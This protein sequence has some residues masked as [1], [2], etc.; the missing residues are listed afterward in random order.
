MKVISPR[1][2]QFRR[3][4]HPFAGRI[5]GCVVGLTI[6]TVVSTTTLGQVPDAPG[7]PAAAPAKAPA[8][9]AAPTSKAPGVTPNSSFLGKDI[10]A[11]DPGTDMFTWD[12]KSWNVNNNRIFQARFEKY[13]N[14]PEATSAEDRQYQAIIAEV[15]TR[16]APGNATREN[17]DYAFKLLNRG[18]HYDIDARL[19]DALADAV[20]TVWM[21]KRQ[22][23]R[24]YTANQAMNYE[25]QLLELAGAGR[26]QATQAAK[27][28][29]KK[30]RTPGGRRGQAAATPPAATVTEESA[31]AKEAVQENADY[32]TRR[33][34]EMIARQ[35]GNDVKRELSE[36]QAKVEYQ[37]LIVQFFLQ[38]RFQHVLMATR[39]YRAIF[40]DGDSK[41]N[42]GDETK[43]LFTKTS[44]MPPTVTTLDSLANEAVRDVR[45]GV[46]AFDFLLSKEELESA[47]RRL[48]ESFTMGEFLPE[49]RTLAREKK[50]RVVTF[51][52]KSNELLAKMETKDF[53]GAERLIAELATIAKDFDA[54]RPQG[55]IDT[56]R[57]ASRL[58]L[59]AARNAAL[60]GDKETLRT[61]L[62]AAAEIWPLNPEL[63]EISQKIF[64]Q[65]D[66][67]QRAILDFD[68]LYGQKNYRRILEES[69]RFIAATAQDA[70]RQAQLKAV[71]QDMQSIEGALLRAE[72][73]KRQS[74]FAGAWESVEKL[75]GQFPDDGKLNQARADLTTQAADFVRTLRSAEEMEK[76]ADVGAA[77]AWFLK[78]QKI[79]PASDFAQQGIERMTKVIFPEG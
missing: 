69:A 48:A 37:A 20:Y 73:M 60:S 18:S 33:W 10:A 3:T 79:Y 66:V 32:K 52:H 13:L 56:A 67:M 4:L 54:S 40:S 17:V 65:G 50:R 7:A 64:N 59:A 41:L 16:L 47:S 36:I 28:S 71:L 1:R 38:R 76:R 55:M 62:T 63:A 2:R 31:D 26:R 14:A 27:E 9:A 77:L 70:E 58:H 29:N 39:F 19:C 44:G 21:A 22:Q 6:Y 53:T 74:N 8:P 51:V 11:F 12:G 24:L 61:E 46:R 5:F 75:A 23:Q 35:K 42:I 30:M 25:I 49:I 34:A 72:E 15:L 57:Q 78:A 43:D 68:Q 45:E